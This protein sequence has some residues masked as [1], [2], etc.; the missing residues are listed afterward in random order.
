V[1]RRLVS[2]VTDDQTSGA[3]LNAVVVAA[4]CVRFCPYLL[5][6][7]SDPPDALAISGYWLF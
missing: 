5:S 6:D 1:G 4:L 2:T 7:R 3:S